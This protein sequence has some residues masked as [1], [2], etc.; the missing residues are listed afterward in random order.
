MRRSLSILP[1]VLAGPLSAGTLD[2]VIVETVPVAPI[3][4]PMMVSDW[5]GPYAGLAFGTADVS[6]ARYYETDSDDEFAFDDVADATDGSAFGAFGGYNLQS[7]SFVYGGE[8]AYYSLNEVG[9]AN[10]GD[11]V[12]LL[13]DVIDLRARVGY[14]FGDILVYGALGFSTASLNTDFEGAEIDDSVYGTNI[15]LGV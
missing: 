4:P 2:P 8:L 5:S 15:G 14:S 11:E 3:A 1:F 12:E 6:D 7:G 10:D 13:E 9:Y